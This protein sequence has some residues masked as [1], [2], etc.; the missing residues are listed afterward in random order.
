MTDPICLQ[1]MT[2]DLT[3]RIGYQDPYLQTI[4]KKLLNVTQLLIG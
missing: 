1:R 3:Q 4:L 2:I